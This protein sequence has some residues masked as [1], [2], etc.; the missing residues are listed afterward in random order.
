[1]RS[2]EARAERGFCDC[3]ARSMLCTSDAIS[4]H[5]SNELRAVPEF[6]SYECPRPARWHGGCCIEC[7]WQELVRSRRVVRPTH[8]VVPRSAA[9]RMEPNRGR[10]PKLQTMSHHT[11]YFTYFWNV[12]QRRT[13]PKV[14]SKIGDD[15]DQTPPATTP[16]RMGDKRSPPRRRRPNPRRAPHP[17]R[18]WPD[19]APPLGG[20]MQRAGS[21]AIYDLPKQ[22]KRHR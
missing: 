5:G 20:G 7:F 3:S 10:T 14:C 15:R 13:R 4:R 9:G 21:K 8:R 22:V 6:A 19:A 2:P 11:R 1:L 16:N 17:Y 12:P 18:G